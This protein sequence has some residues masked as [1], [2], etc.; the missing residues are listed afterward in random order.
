MRAPPFFFFLPLCAGVAGAAPLSLAE[1]ILKTQG[2]QVV[3]RADGSGCEGYTRLSP[4][5]AAQQVGAATLPIEQTPSAQFQL[6]NQWRIRVSN[7]PDYLLSIVPIGRAVSSQEIA[8]I[9]AKSRDVLPQNIVSAIQRRCGIVVDV[10]HLSNLSKDM[11]LEIT[12]PFGN[13]AFPGN[14]RLSEDSFEMRPHEYVTDLT[15][16]IRDSISLTLTGLKLKNSS[17]NSS[18]PYLTGIQVSLKSA[19]LFRYIPSSCSL[20][21]LHK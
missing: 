6:G 4:R 18:S 19:A 11:V 14:G 17:D 15:P 8:F 20:F 9:N 12:D 7:G 10:R 16:R 21:V 3:C 5:A 2:R 1:V 13:V